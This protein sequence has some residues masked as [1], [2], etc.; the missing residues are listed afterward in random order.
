MYKTKIYVYPTIHDKGRKR[1]PYIANLIQG[2]EEVGYEVTNFKK[3]PKRGVI[4]ILRH[5]NANTFIINWPENL[6]SLRLGFFQ[7][8][9]YCLLLVAIRLSGKKIIWILHNKE[10]HSNKS[11]FSSF[12]MWITAKMSNSVVTHAFHGIK[13]FKEKY[14]KSNITAFPHPVYPDIS[15]PKDVPIKYD[16]IIWG[17]IDPYKNILSF[18]KYVE[19]HNDELKQYTFLICGSCKNV[20]LANQI[21][22]L[23]E[24]NRNIH[25]ENKFFSDA[26]LAIAIAQSRVILYTY[27]ESSVLSSGSVIYSLSAKK[28]IIGPNFGNFQELASGG[29]IVV[30]ETYEEIFKL[31]S[32]SIVNERKIDEYHNQYTWNSFAQYIK[33]IES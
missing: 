27:K 4:D 24:R 9:V 32:S 8:I 26:D 13:F 11:Y 19:D 31:F 23:V 17:A 15:F 22:Q 16:F 3:L 30:Y 14:R 33:Q 6:Y 29:Q 10:A 7:V 1:N 25:F 5:F 21:N 12:S 20:S 28:L 2:L 18:L